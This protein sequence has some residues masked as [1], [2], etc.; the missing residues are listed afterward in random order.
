MVRGFNPEQSFCTPTLVGKGEPSSVMTL[1]EMKMGRW[2]PPFMSSTLPLGLVGVVVLGTR[3]VVGVLPM[4]P[5]AEPAPP[6][7]G[8]CRPGP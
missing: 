4:L 5:A 1:P 3:P 6:P 7:V 8:V 2:M